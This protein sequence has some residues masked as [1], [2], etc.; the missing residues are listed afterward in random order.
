M[1]EEKMKRKTL[2]ISILAIILCFS[3]AF[4]T[5]AATLSPK[6]LVL[7]SIDNLDLDYSEKF[8]DKSS[9]TATYQIN[10]FDGSSLEGV[11]IPRG[12][13]LDCAYKLDVPGQKSAIDVDLSYN[14]KT[15]Q[16]QLYLAQDKL[17]ITKSFLAALNELAPDN[18]LGDLSKYPEYLYI[19]DPMMIQIWKSMLD[20]PN[21]KITEETK[22]LLKFFVEAIPEEYFH[23][24]AS[25]VTLELDQAGF[26]ET[27]YNILEKVKNE[28]ELFADIMVNITMASDTTGTMSSMGSPEQMK[29]D[30][31]NGI[32]DAVNSGSWPTREQ[33]Q[34]MSSF[35][36]VK[37]FKYQSSIMP[38]GKS[39]FDASLALQ[40][41]IGFAGQLDINSDSKGKKDNQIGTYNIKFSFTEPGGNIINGK[42]K[43][44]MAIKEDTITQ[45]LVL[46]ASSKKNNG[47]IDF[48][49]EV[50][51]QSNQQVESDLNIDVP[52]LTSENSMDMTE[53]SGNIFG[54]GGIVGGSGGGGGGQDSATVDVP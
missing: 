35:V 31:I 16:G 25:N 27:I 7:K 44:D 12:T 54:G 50:T 5:L 37:T 4:V 3:F 11:N 51:G 14:N 13:S 20:Y 33:I 45:N 39:K 41:G 17:I 48:D 26:E 40:P 6:D 21:A 29:T 42:F 22:A 34:M 8:Y 30:I 38:G 19:S 18:E 24:S 43:G 52:T 32:N 49:V 9:G 36:Q 23:A 47:T 53:V 28:K 15:Y 10:K 46:S 2:L 1:G